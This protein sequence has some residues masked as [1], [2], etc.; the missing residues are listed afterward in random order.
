MTTTA[1]WLYLKLG[2]PLPDVA[3]D[4]FA[5]DRSEENTGDVAARQRARAA[6]PMQVVFTGR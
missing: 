5:M 2:M 1:D 4:D 6:Q 3:D